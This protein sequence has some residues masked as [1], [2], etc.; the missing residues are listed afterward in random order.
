MASSLAPIITYYS[1]IDDVENITTKVDFSTVTVGDAG[2]V[3]TPHKIR[4]KNESNSTD[5]LSPII[6]LTGTD[7]EIISNEEWCK[8]K[9][10]A[11]NTVPIDTDVYGV[12]T[13]NITTTK[14]LNVDIE[15][16]TYIDILLQMYM[17]PGTL[18]GQYDWKLALKYEYTA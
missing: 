16:G 1:I 18:A 9:V 10:V 13:N 4:I 14:E 2:I 8:I 15:A 3:T 12:I 6:Y 17:P 7:A 5:A 11:D